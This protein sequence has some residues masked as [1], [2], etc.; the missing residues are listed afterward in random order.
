MERTVRT[1]TIS[2]IKAHFAGEPFSDCPEFIGQLVQHK[3]LIKVSV[4]QYTYDL[5]KLNNRIMAE[6]TM[7]IKH[8]LL[9]YNR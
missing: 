8:K 7:I 1:F 2:Q 5:T 6:I 4:N 3:I 9:T